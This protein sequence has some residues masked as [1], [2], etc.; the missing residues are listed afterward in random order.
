MSLISD[1]SSR[2][3]NTVPTD[4]ALCS[5]V[6]CHLQGPMKGYRCQASTSYKMHIAFNDAYIYI[7]IYIYIDKL[8]EGNQHAGFII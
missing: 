4:K 2:G 7:Y 3:A 6:W 1:K 8:T 5:T